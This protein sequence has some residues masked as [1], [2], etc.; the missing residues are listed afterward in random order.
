MADRY[1]E[2]LNRF[3]PEGAVRLG[4]YCIGGI[5]VLEMAR[6][7]KDAGRK[8]LSPVV[9]WDAPNMNSALY[10][11]HDEPWD[12][13]ANITR[14]E[15]LKE[16]LG[17][18]RIETSVD[19]GRAPPTM[20]TEPVGRDAAM[21]KLPGVLPML[22]F[23]KRMV[24]WILNW[25]VQMKIVK[26]LLIRKPVPYELR[27]GYCRR[28]ML[29]AA[30]RHHCPVYSD[31]VLYFRSDCLLGRYISMSGWWDDIYMGFAELTNG[32]FEAYAIGGVHTDILDI[33]EM[34]SIVRERFAEAEE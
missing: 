18:V 23:A 28:T 26:S 12:S 8:V 20:Y 24:E 29:K 22:R 30:R 32:P 9:V 19:R 15:K 16:K 13:A 25:P 34:A 1:V 5:I 31:H 6:R 11:I 3:Y 21:R 2:E 17:S 33:P 27:A 4:G 14:F 10:H 7:L